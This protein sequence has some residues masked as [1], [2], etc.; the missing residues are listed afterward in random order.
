MTV[1]LFVHVNRAAQKKI[2]KTHINSSDKTRNF[3]M[4]RYVLLQRN[5]YDF[6]YKYF[7]ALLD[8]GFSRHDSGVNLKL[9]QEWKKTKILRSPHDFCVMSS[10]EIH[11]TLFLSVCSRKRHITDILYIFNRFASINNAVGTFLPHR[12]ALPDPFSLNFY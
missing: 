11:F 6:Y 9:T 12:S 10:L 5:Y 1:R 2:N 4:Y 3:L 7:T 8:G